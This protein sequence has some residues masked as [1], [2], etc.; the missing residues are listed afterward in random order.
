MGEDEIRDRT[1]TQLVRGKP[2]SAYTGL[3]S[4]WN[5]LAEKLGELSRVLQDEKDV[6][7]TLQA[8]AQAATDTV[9]GAEHA[10]ISVVM[11]RR[12]VETRAATG[13]LPRDVDQAQ[14][15][16]GEGPCLDSLYEQSSVRLADLRTEQRW[17][18]FA[19]QAADL[20]VGSML[21]VQLYVRGEDLGALNLHSTTPDAFDDESE[22]VALLF[23][24]HAAV[25][26]A[27]AQDHEQMQ[28]ALG[29]RDT[30]GTAKGILM[31][32]YKITGHD[33]F[34]LLVVASQTTNVKLYEVADFLVRTGHLASRES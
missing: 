13:E 19:A 16:T 34:R 3:D 20:G 15:Q 33:A 18:K 11:R 17:P 29:S 6:D 2:S 22:Q 27:G 30:I 14:Y 23:A 31:E 8:I 26:M 24:A 28:T 32:R 21:A 9:P 10:S 5:E 25:A 12:R 4:G 7:A 1:E